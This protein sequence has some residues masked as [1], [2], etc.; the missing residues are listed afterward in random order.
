MTVEERGRSF[1]QLSSSPALYASPALSP[2]HALVTVAA[3]PC[4]MPAPSRLPLLI[5]PVHNPSRR[6][7]LRSLKS[8]DPNL[9][10]IQLADP[11]CFVFPAIVKEWS[12][13]AGGRHCV[14]VPLDDCEEVCCGAADCSVDSGVGV[15]VH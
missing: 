7:N 5:F 6:L 3:N 9:S 8:R 10:S 1:S 2:L 15:S 14:S 12:L 13:S 4:Q 11:A